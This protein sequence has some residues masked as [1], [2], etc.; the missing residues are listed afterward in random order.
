LQ[1]APN[2]IQWSSRGYLIG[3]NRL[4]YLAYTDDIVLCSANMQKL[5]LMLDDVAG[6]C[7][8]IGLEI[9]V[10]KT[11]FM[12]TDAD[13]RLELAGSATER[14]WEFIYLGH[15]VMLRRDHNKEIGRRIGAA[16]ATFKRVQALMTNKNVPM[17]TK[18][19]Y[20]NTSVCALLR[21]AHPPLT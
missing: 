6:A 11:K 8:Q 17:T 20:F 7:R 21:S 9:N 19:R 10:A 2:R 3:N 14:V 12:S 4:R 13:A 1:L 16:W 18:R 15:K 5:Q